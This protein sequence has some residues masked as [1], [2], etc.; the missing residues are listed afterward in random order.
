M[1][2]LVDKT[3]LIVAYILE[4]NKYTE[5][6]VSSEHV[7]TITRCSLVMSMQRCIHISRLSSPDS[8]RKSRKGIASSNPMISP[9]YRR[10]Q[11]R[12]LGVIE[13]MAIVTY[14]NLAFFLLN[15][16]VQ[17]IIVFCL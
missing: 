8:C 1:I 6:A 13:E 5:D 11:L 7:S 15:F 16:S 10:Y 3:Q 12:T 2:D 4:Q 9:T 17:K 14:V